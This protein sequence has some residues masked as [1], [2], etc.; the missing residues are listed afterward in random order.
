MR[1]PAFWWRP[2]GWPSRLLSPLAAIY[3]VAAGARMARLGTAAAVPVVCIG[4]LTVGGA[5]KTPTAIAVAQWFAAAGRQPF[6]LSR[7]YGGASA[8]PLRVDPDRHTA[9]EVGDEPLLLARV[10]PTI[11][12]RDRVAGAKAACEAGAGS[13]VMDDGFQNPALEKKLSIVVVDGARGI[14]NGGVFPAGP[15][16]VPLA[17]QLMCAHAVLLVGKGP[18]GETVATA[19]RQLDLPVFHGRLEPDEGALAGLRGLPVLA[20]AG[21][22]YPEKFFATLRNAGIDVRVVRAF[23]DHHRYRA[24]EAFGLVKRAEGEQLT[25]VTTEKDLVRLTGRDELAALRSMVRALPVRLAVSEEAA[26]RDFV[27]ARTL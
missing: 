21:I 20:F 4:N 13:I 15:L 19:A 9:A 24:G 10:A 14:G 7:G 8:G 12:S 17:A 22:G 6:L 18:G 2:A 1:D 23:P 11:V 3:G 25:L 27:L 26:L 16:R 5:G